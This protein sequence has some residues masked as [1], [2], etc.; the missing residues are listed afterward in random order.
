VDDNLAVGGLGGDQAAREGALRHQSQGVGPL[1]ADGRAIV[2]VPV[3]EPLAG[4][5]ERLHQHLSRF[6]RESA[7]DDEHAVLVDVG[8][9]RGRSVS[10]CVLASLHGPV[11]AAPGA[12]DPLDVRGRAGPAEVE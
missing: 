5:P 1:L 11:D 9:D 2:A 7:A 10:Q 3:E 6:R 12:N 8:R 4:G